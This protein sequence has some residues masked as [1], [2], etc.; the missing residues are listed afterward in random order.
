MRES[1][2]HARH[3]KCQTLTLNINNLFKKYLEYILKYNF[4][5]FS[6]KYHRQKTG[7]AMSTH[8][9]PSYACIFMGYLERQALTLIPGHLK[10]FMWKCYTDMLHIWPHGEDSFNKFINFLNSFHKTAKFDNRTYK[11]PWHSV[12]L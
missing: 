10:P 8:M 11:V 1:K 6:G 12:V 4:F 7:T 9:A 3:L 5:E 2:P